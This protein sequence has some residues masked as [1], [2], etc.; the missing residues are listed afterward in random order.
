[1]NFYRIF[2]GSDFSIGLQQVRGILEFFNENFNLPVKINITGLAKWSTLGWDNFHGAGAK[3]FL[4][5]TNMC[6]LQE[7]MMY[8][9]IP[10]HVWNNNGRMMKR[11]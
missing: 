1:M 11:Q 3:V 10:S 8:T 6:V 5:S 4:S 2:P 7:S 9:N